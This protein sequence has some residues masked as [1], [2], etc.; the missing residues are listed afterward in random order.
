[1][2][3]VSHRLILTSGA[4]AEGITTDHIVTQI[5]KDVPKNVES[6]GLSR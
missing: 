1:M 6:V 5:L 3:M 2:G 4:E